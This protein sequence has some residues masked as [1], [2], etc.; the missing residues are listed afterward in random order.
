M[1]AVS[2]CMNRF[3]V[4][5]DDACATCVAVV[6]G[7]GGTNR[8]RRPIHAL[9]VTRATAFSSPIYTLLCC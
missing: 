2:S 5:F 6:G 7:G 1:C 8:Y 9:R 3:V 4:A